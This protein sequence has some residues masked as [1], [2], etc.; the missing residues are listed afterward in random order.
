MMMILR[1]KFYKQ[2]TMFLTSQKIEILY[3]D[4]I[5]MLSS[6]LILSKYPILCLIDTNIVFYTQIKKNFDMMSFDSGF[7]SVPGITRLF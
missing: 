3:N 6:H 5:F 2:L 4:D 7:D 1:N